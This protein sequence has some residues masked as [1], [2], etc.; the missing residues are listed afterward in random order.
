MRLLLC[1]QRS[2]GVVIILF[3]VTVGLEALLLA[4][5]ILLVS[6]VR[7]VRVGRVDVVGKGE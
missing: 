3:G 2:S 1:E 6:S 4:L 5:I 7:V